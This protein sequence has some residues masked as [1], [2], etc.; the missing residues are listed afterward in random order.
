MGTDISLPKPK[1]TMT[2]QV[3]NSQSSAAETSTSPKLC[4]IDDDPIFTAVL[5]ARLQ[6]QFPDLS[7]ET[8]SDPV[9]SP[10]Y[11]IYFIDNDFNGD[12]LISVL[13][14]Q[15]RELN[16]NAL[17]VASSNTLDAEKLVELMNGGC[18]AAYEKSAPEGCAEVFSVIENY[19]SVL[20]RQ[21]SLNNGKPLQ[22]LVQSLQ[23]LL[24]EWN[25][26]LSHNIQ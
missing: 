3:N 13:L 1:A 20:K 7:I 17:V 24:R 22:G 9:I 23:S 2:T 12:S 18:N 15:I 14:R 21:L 19:L 16:P 4:I 25:R 6:N 5:K 10:G 8:E 26:R 11:D